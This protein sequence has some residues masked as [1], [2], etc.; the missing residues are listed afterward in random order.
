MDIQDIFSIDISQYVTEEH[1][2]AGETIIREGDV[3]HFFAVITKGKAKCCITQENGKVGL[4]DLLIAPCTLG[5]LELLGVQ[6]YGSGIIAITDCICQMINL[7]TCN[8]MILEDNYFLRYL[9]TALAK[10]T[11]KHARYIS[12][13]QTYPLRNRLITFL[14]KTQYNGIYTGTLTEAAS[15]LGVSYR[16][17]LFVLA[18]L[19]KEELLKKENGMYLISNVEELEKEEIIVVDEF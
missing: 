6:K 17:L 15:Y 19:V 14:L 13:A 7:D 4:V 3:I 10:R 16:H 5:D 11:I 1:F 12:M 18:Q 9:S 8:E 2:Q